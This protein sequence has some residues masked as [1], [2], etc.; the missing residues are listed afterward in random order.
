MH[1]QS[2][3]SRTYHPQTDGQMEQIN[4]VVEDYLYYFCSYYQDN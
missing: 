4:Q 3:V 1:I 2:A